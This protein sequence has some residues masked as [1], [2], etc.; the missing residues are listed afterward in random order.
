MTVAD[1][2][3]DGFLDILVS[4]ALPQYCELLMG[5][6]GGVFSRSGELSVAIEG[7]S[8]SN[9]FQVTMMVVGDVDGDGN[10]DVLAAGVNTMHFGNGAGGFERSTNFKAADRYSRAIVLGDVDRDGDL[11]LFSANTEMPNEL[12]LNNGD[13]T[14]ETDVNFQ[15]PAGSQR[16]KSN[17]IALGDLNADG[18]LDVVV[19]N[20]GPQ[21]NAGQVNEL[22]WGDGSGGFD[23]G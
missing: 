1:L 18:F 19:S 12:M 6:G 2:D 23:T 15:K 22:Y 10:L 9:Y 7:V 3:N 5:T 11:D 14:F 17:S 20:R 4:N 21:V 8:G 16:Y 13:G